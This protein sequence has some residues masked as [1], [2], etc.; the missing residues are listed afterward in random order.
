MLAVFRL[1]KEESDK[2]PRY[3]TPGF[4]PNR[5]YIR[6]MKKYGVLPADFDPASSPIDIFATDQAYW[7]TYWH[8]PPSP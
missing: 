7:R 5:Q 1:G 6:E 8:T 4:R 3:G 2:R